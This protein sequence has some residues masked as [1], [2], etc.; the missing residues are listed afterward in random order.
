[1]GYG[2]DAPVVDNSPSRQAVAIRRAFFIE[3]TA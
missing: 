2:S 1:M 3:D